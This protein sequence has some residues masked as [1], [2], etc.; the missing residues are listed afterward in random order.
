MCSHPTI[1]LATTADARAISEL[2]LP[3]ATKFIAHEFSEE[4]QRNLFRS[5]E[6][7]AIEGFFQAG[8]RYHVAAVDW[9]VVGVVG[10]RDNSHVHHLFVAEDHQRCG[11]A[12][13]L[14][15]V[16]RGAC[17]EAGNPGRFTVFSS[18]YA[19]D[20]YRAFGFIESGPPEIKDEVIATPM[21]YEV[22]KTGDFSNNK[23]NEP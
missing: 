23:A 20:V 1:R 8:Y 19:L 14:W 13:D 11:L 16:A 2:I 6:P 17:L 15:R 7:D 18:K 21:E 4:G 9:R 22:V 10:V 5:M 3:L 12:T